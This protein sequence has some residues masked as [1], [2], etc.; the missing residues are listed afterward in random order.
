[1]IHV[2][3]LNKVVI[4]SMPD[5]KHIQT[6]LSCFFIQHDY[7]PDE[8][9]RIYRHMAL[10]LHS[11]KCK[12][13]ELDGV[14][15]AF[16]DNMGL[17]RKGR[18]D[19]DA[20]MKKL[21]RDIT[22]KLAL[23]CL[24][25]NCKV[26]S[27]PIVSCF[28]R[29]L[30]MYEGIL[31]SNIL[32]V[33]DRM[34]TYIRECLK[35][36]SYCKD[37]FNVIQDRVLDITDQLHQ[38][39]STTYTFPAMPI[40]KHCT[41]RQT[42][43]DLSEQTDYQTHKGGEN[44]L[45]YFFD[46]YFPYIGCTCFCYADFEQLWQC[47]VQKLKKENSL[48]TVDF[49]C[50]SNEQGAS[51]PQQV[52]TDQIIFFP[53]EEPQSFIPKLAP[54][55]PGFTLKSTPLHRQLILPS[56]LIAPTVS[57]SQSTDAQEPAHSIDAHER[58]ESIDT[59]ESV[60]SHIQESCDPQKPKTSINA[61]MEE[62]KCAVDKRKNREHFNWQDEQ[63]NLPLKRR[64]TQTNKTKQTKQTK[65][66]KRTNIPPLNLMNLKGPSFPSFTQ[67][68]K[69]PNPGFDMAKSTRTRRRSMTCKV[70]HRCD[71]L[72][73]ELIKKKA[74]ELPHLRP[75]KNNKNWWRLSS[76]S[77]FFANGPCDEPAMYIRGIVR[78][79]LTSQ[80]FPNMLYPKTYIYDYLN[81]TVK[82]IVPPTVYK[83]AFAKS[84][85]DN[86]NSTDNDIVVMHGYFCNVR[87]VR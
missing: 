15:E 56:M 23:R 77:T 1:M 74:P 29:I 36:N 30:S 84:A 66:T 25:S 24:Q 32:A 35:K 43:H 7:S 46:H 42:D 19:G 55:H 28:P 21:S 4:I 53:G 57:L 70:K 76:T 5:I 78:Q 87:L 3:V 81:W 62:I 82:K 61:P 39:R 41:H 6:A 37:C 9:R 44:Q 68:Y 51:L 13:P 8:L 75:Y 59:Q 67:S 54:R 27:G 86:L 38:P 12:I 80:C 22:D 40:F 79:I 2:S 48:V 20:C 60:Q 47:C 72:W 85:S 58:I 34:F 52:T 83:Q 11:D 71:L 16:K 45:V 73:T 17:V 14:F 26:R 49:I 31:P 63:R 50:F 65:Q 69:K 33:Y 18:R 10:V 64:R